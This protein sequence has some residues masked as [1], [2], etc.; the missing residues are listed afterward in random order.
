M[1]RL[2]ACA[3]PENMQFYSMEIHVLEIPRGG[4]LKNQKFEGSVELNWNFNREG[5]TFLEQH[6]GLWVFVTI[7]D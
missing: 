5:M 6:I 1:T 3:V 2:G 4:G 7:S